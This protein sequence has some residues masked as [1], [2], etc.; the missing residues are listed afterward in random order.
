MTREIAQILD[1]KLFEIEHYSLRIY[2]LAGFVVFMIIASLLWIMLKKIISKSNRLD[3]SKK[4]SI[5]QL[6]K[7]IYIVFGITTSLHILGINIS[8]LLAGSAAL[9]VGVGLG[10]QNLFNDFVSGI[11]LLSDKTLKVG[12][13]IEV[14]SMIYKVQEINFRTSTM[15]GRDE[16]YIIMPN[17]ALTGNNLTNWTHEKISSRF[18]VTI[19]VNYSTDVLKLIP[20]LVSAAKM[21]PQVL[22]DPEPFVRFMDYG[23]SSLDFSIFFYTNEIFWVEQIKSDIRIEI[24]K[25]F[26]INNITVPFPQRV[27]HMAKD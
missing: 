16:S 3:P 4:Y 13:I 10:L 14:N 12:D 6:T 25:A 15:L 18:D 1:T 20:I 24:F 7:Y 11:I 9:L 22:Q 23:D 8:V 17:S 27:I 19:G 5:T 26:K 2:N 21:H